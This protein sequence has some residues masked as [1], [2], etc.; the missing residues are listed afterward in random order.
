MFGTY[1]I[2]IMSFLLVPTKLRLFCLYN[3]LTFTGCPEVNRR[4]ILSVIFW[5]PCI[6]IFILKYLL[7]GQFKKK[8][9]NQEKILRKVFQVLRASFMIMIQHGYV[10]SFPLEGVVLEWCGG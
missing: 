9:K 4:K 6:R 10:L 1:T 3:E 7:L 5:T 8:K 2:Y